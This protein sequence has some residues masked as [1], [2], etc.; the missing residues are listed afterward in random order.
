MG[1]GKIKIL[2]RDAIFKSQ[3]NWIFYP[4]CWCVSTRKFLFYLGK[5]ERR[6]FGEINLLE[7]SV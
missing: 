1:H 7:I 6:T 4:Q 3:P 2:G 5:F